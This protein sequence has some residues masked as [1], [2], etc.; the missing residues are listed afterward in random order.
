MSQRTTEIDYDVIRWF[1][2][3]DPTDNRFKL[4]CKS[5]KNKD[6]WERLVKAETYLDTTKNG[7]GDNDAHNAVSD[8]LGE[9]AQHH[10]EIDTG[11]GVGNGLGDAYSAI[12]SY[13]SVLVGNKVDA[14]VLSNINLL[15]TQG[16]D[17]V[18]SV[19]KEFNWSEVVLSNRINDVGSSVQQLLVDTTNDDDAALSA[20]AVTKPFFEAT[21]GSAKRGASDLQLLIALVASRW[22]AL[23]YTDPL[24]NG[25]GKIPFVTGKIPDKPFKNVTADDIIGVT[26]GLEISSKTSRSRMTVDRLIDTVI[27]GADGLVGHMLNSKG[28]RST[29]TLGTVIESFEKARGV[30]GTFRREFIQKFRQGLK[31]FVYDVARSIIEKVLTY[32]KKDVDEDFGELHVAPGEVS[33]KRNEIQT[34]TKAILAEFLFNNDNVFGSGS[35]TIGN[36]E[37]LK[38]IGESLGSLTKNVVK[39]VISGEFDIGHNAIMESHASKMLWEH[40]FKR[41]SSLNDYTKEFYTEY[42][43]IHMRHG[44]GWKPVDDKDYDKLSIINGT[45]GNYR[46]NMKKDNGM[47]LFGKDIP[48]LKKNT[49]KR[50]YYKDNT[51]NLQSINAADKDKDFFR[52]LY[53]KVY[54]T[55]SSSSPIKYE[56]MDLPGNLTRAKK[57]RPDVIGGLIL[58]PKNIGKIVTKILFGVKKAEVDVDEVIEPEKKY[59]DFVDKISITPNLWHR[60]TKGYYKLDKKGNRKHTRGELGTAAEYA[61]YYKELDLPNRCSTS[62]WPE[63]SCSDFIFECLLKDDDKA[64]DRCLKV[65]KNVSFNVI[66]L[67]EINKMHPMIAKQALDKFGFRVK[68]DS[69]GKPE[70]MEDVSEWIRRLSKEDATKVME[71]NEDLLRYLNLLSA[72]INANPSVIDPSIKAAEIVRIKE[73]VSKSRYGRESKIK[74][75]I[76]PPHEKVRQRKWDI[77]EA[78]RKLRAKTLPLFMRNSRLRF[79]FGLHSTPSAQIFVR[80]QLGGNPV[81]AINQFRTLRKADDPCHIIGELVQV[82]IERLKGRNKTLSKKTLE[83]IDALRDGFKKN[84]TKLMKYKG[85]IEAYNEQLDHLGDY[86]EDILSKKKLEK[87]V[88]AY[89]HK[90][91]KVYD[92]GDAIT[93]VLKMLEDMYSKSV[94]KKL[95]TYDTRRIRL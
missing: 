73:P 80:G 18:S 15:R 89:K 59:N 56:G 40:V 34:A 22:T 6:A 14:T 20:G 67:R 21:D 79:P 48:D 85:Y 37:Y 31:D 55:S 52:K 39:G 88:D 54:T 83:E 24:F 46:F 9:I 27:D 25:T 92:Y 50:I 74:Y 78:N 41:W 69:V 66:A 42:I 95:P 32:V 43:E 26:K 53:H 3:T 60:D 65:A 13:A 84:Y 11:A 47:T 68:T 30:E 12:D 4:L 75:Y 7:M 70:S 19:S 62:L 64:L 28:I 72:Y 5:M 45:S 77:F 33:T 23:D 91:E 29:L 71:N 58:F 86:K 81:I 1:F 17:Y 38:R 94:G 63:E 10:Q 36:N 82:Q 57:N 61:D 16:T 35:V 51:G 2:T 76:Q 90:Q 93:K 87:L 8:I 49:Y 44:R